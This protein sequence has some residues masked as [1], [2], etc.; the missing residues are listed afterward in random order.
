MKAIIDP[1]LYYQPNI[2]PQLGYVYARQ[3]GT[4]DIVVAVLNLSERKD[5]KGQVAAV[6]QVNRDGDIMKA[7][8]VPCAIM[9]E[10]MHFVG[11]CSIPDIKVKWCKRPQNDRGQK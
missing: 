1:L 4:F 8:N 7:T 5:T 6:I 11:T 3:D 9:K 2:D 10:N